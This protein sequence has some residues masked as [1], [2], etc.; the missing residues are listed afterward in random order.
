MMLQLETLLQT[1]PRWGPTSTLGLPGT[2]YPTEEMLKLASA[3][4]FVYVGY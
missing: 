4:P 3:N 2:V 1:M